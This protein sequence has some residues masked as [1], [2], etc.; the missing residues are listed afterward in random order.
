VAVPVETLVAPVAGGE[1][2][3]WVDGDG[4]PV[5]ALHGGP[6]LSYDYL[7]DMVR[8][9]SAGYRVATY[10]Q[11][12]LAPS[13]TD[14]PFGIPQEVDDACA[15]L[16]ALGWEQAFVVGHSWGGHLVLHLAISRPERLLGVLS[17]DPLGGVGDGGAAALEA[18]FAEWIAA[19]GKGAD[20][21]PQY[22]GEPTGLRRV[23]PAYFADP[24][25]APPMPQ[26]RSSPAAHEGVWASLREEM[27]RLEA[28]LGTIRVPVGFLAGA[29][30]P[31]PPEVSAGAT[32]AAI[33]GAWLELVEDAGHF[34]WV[35][36]PGCVRSA[37]DRLAAGA[38]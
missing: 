2:R 4:P 31:I 34:P 14:G 3:G 32:A 20:E 7:D 24:A 21:A 6:G 12:G 30:S 27:P 19:Q 22:E 11:R 38:D 33:P 36:R 10:Q 29:A 18:R 35:E 5:L 26:I 9:L 13:A 15:V 17:V 8:E 1:L 37:V 28:A 16:D 25:A 23:W